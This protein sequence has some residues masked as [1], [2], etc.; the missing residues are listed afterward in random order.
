MLSA[1]G[2]DMNWVVNKMLPEERISLRIRTEE[3]IYET[4]VYQQHRLIRIHKLRN[5]SAGPEFILYEWTSEDSFN[6][7]TEKSINESVE[8]AKALNR[9]IEQEQK[10]RTKDDW[11]RINGRRL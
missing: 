6:S 1:H 5:T 4:Q 7:I 3:G 8:R 9:G 10:R 2:C 11:L